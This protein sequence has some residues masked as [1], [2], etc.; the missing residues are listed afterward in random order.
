MVGKAV[1]LER[2]CMG[3]DRQNRPS[4]LKMPTN[5]KLGW[6]TFRERI[7]GLHA[8]SPYRTRKGNQNREYGSV[9]QRPKYA[10]RRSWLNQNH[11]R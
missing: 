8:A 6:L 7:V 10:S 2:K 1:Q 4:R 5:V 11:A 9:L 3:M